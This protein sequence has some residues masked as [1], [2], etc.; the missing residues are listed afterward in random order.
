M[1]SVFRKLLL[2]ASCS[3]LAGCA[4]PAATEF[5][6]LNV[7]KPAQA[8]QYS[9]F[10]VGRYASLT[11]DPEL[12][13][14]NFVRASAREPDDSILLE[15][16]IFSLLLAGERDQALALAKAGQKSVDEISSL[17]RL[18]LAISEMSSDDFKEARIL[19]A[20]GETGLFNRI[21]SRSIAAWAALGEDDE[22]GSKSQLIESL[23]GDDVL[24]G[25]S[26]YMLG[27][28]QMSAGNDEDA[29]ETFEAVWGERMR[30]AVAC[31][32]YIRLLSAK[33]ETDKALEIADQ[34]R[35]EVGPNPAVD[36]LSKKLRAGE[37]ISVKRLKPTEGAAIAVYSLGTA[38]ATETEDDIAS[39]YFN[40]A[41]MLDPELDIARTMLGSTLDYSDRGEEAVEILRQVSETSPFYA[42]SRG[43]LAWAL[44]RL[45]QEDEALEVARDG[46]AKTGD[47][48]LTIQLGDLYRTVGKFDEAYRWFDSVVTSDEA[49]GREDWRSYYARAVTLH[50][51]GDWEGAE[52]DLLRAVEIDDGQPQVLNY[53][54]YSWVDRGENLQKGFDLIQEAV[55]LS[56]NSGYIVDSLG[57][58]YYMLG[59][60]PQ[61][62]LYLER[63]VE[64]SP[65]DPTLND[66]LG[67][68]Y[69]RAGRELE[70]RFQWRHALALDP[71]E[72]DI[73]GIEAKLASGLKAP[74]PSVMAG[75]SG[76]T[77]PS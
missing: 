66:H 72:A 76:V 58:A 59:Q 39:V 14:E 30:L 42:T 29:L 32:H 48:D 15:R 10:L 31:E 6:W 52:R 51:L 18:T 54:G 38:L 27:L 4:T 68:A 61:A 57:W 71:D 43:Q 44:L 73:A 25:V 62:V 67:D 36:S 12:A 22:D 49:E 37:P 45:G 70:A 41:L 21:V 17:T 1:V 69:W 3:A 55:R 33:G 35:R 40:L 47:R 77:E 23:V 5:D 56:P 13:A 20:N 19:L 46:Q 16:A 9:D 74:E 28:I 34:F 65:D 50:E 8:D 60:Y 7:A 53:L 75:E 11:N 26:L 24:D 2:A 63:A 64:L